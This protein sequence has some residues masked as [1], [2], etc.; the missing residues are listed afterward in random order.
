MAIYYA[1]VEG[2]SYKEI[3]GIMN[4]PVGTVVS[5][6]PNR[7]AWIEA[8]KTLPQRVGNRG[9]SHRRSRMAGVGA[10]NRVHAQRPN[11][12]DGD[13]IDVGQS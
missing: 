3:V 5:R 11:R 8:Q 1:D 2:F 13:G 9:H 6:R 10:L 4:I 12:V 7:I